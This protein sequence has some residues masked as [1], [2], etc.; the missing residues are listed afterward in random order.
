MM[1]NHSYDNYLGAMTGR[2]DGLPVDGE[3]PIR[4]GNPPATVGPSHPTGC[5]PPT[6]P[7]QIPCQSW[8][9]SHEQWNGGAMRRVRPQRRAGGGRLD[10]PP[11][12][13]ARDWIMG[14][15]DAERPALL[16]GV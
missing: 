4:D 8:E 12:P 9:A 5:T 15:W 1:E 16:L 14:H 2:G 7:P 13:A 3:R 6:Q 11:M 10:P